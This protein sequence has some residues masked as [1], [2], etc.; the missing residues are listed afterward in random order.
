MSGVWY[1]ASGSSNILK[2]TYINGFLDVSNMFLTRSDASMAGN[3][4]IGGSAGLNV[5]NSMTMAGVINQLIASPMI[6]NVVTVGGNVSN[7]SYLNGRLYVYY[8]DYHIYMY[9]Y[10]LLCLYYYNDYNILL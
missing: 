4:Y 2:P 6:G 7:D 9:I 10:I 5:N 1:S 3:V 8:D